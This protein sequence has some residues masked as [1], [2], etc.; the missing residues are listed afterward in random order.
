MNA[1]TNT[2]KNFPNGFTSWAET[3][4]EI[5]RFIS[6]H[7]L[8]ESGTIGLIVATQ[9]TGGLYELAEDWADEFEKMNEYGKWDGEFYDEIEAFCNLKNKT[10]N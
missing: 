10:K 8:D 3:H 5:V 1:Q 4:F 9:G 2:N 6:Q 7:E